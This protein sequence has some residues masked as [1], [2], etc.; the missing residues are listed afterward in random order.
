MNKKRLLEAINLITSNE[1]ETPIQVARFNELIL[2]GLDVNTQINQKKLP[3]LQIDPQGFS[4][5]HLAIIHCKRSMVNALL[6]VEHINLQSVNQDG[7]GALHMV[8]DYRDD[9]QQVTQSQK[10]IKEKQIAEAIIA[11]SRD[12]TLQDKAGNTALHKAAMNGNVYVVELFLKKDYLF[13]QQKL[14]S[15]KNKKHKNTVL[16]EVAQNGKQGKHILSLLMRVAS[17]QDLKAKNA[18]DETP[19]VMVKRLIQER[20]LLKVKFPILIALLNLLRIR[21]KHLLIGKQLKLDEKNLKLSEAELK[22]SWEQWKLH[23]EQWKLSWEQWKLSWEQWNKIN[24]DPISLK[25]FSRLTQELNSLVFH[26]KQL[27]MSSAQVLFRISDLMRRLLADEIPFKEILIKIEG[28]YLNTLSEVQRVLQLNAAYIDEL[29]EVEQ[30]LQQHDYFAWKEEKANLA[31]SF[32]DYQKSLPDPK[33]SVHVPY[34]NEGSGLAR[35]AISYYQK[36][37][38]EFYRQRY[39]TAIELLKKSLQCYDQAPHLTGH[40]NFADAYYLLGRCYQK[41]AEFSSALAVRTTHYLDAQKYLEVSRDIYLSLQDYVQ[42]E[43]VYQDLAD[44]QIKQS[45]SHYEKMQLQVLSSSDTSHQ[46][47]LCAHFALAGFYTVLNNRRY[48]NSPVSNPELEQALIAREAYHYSLAYELTQGDSVPDAHLVLQREIGVGYNV[49]LGTTNIQQCVA[50]FAFEPTS[51]KLVLAHFDKFSGPLTFIEQLLSQFPKEAQLEIYLTGGRDRSQFGRPVSDNN[52]NQ[53]MKQLYA[54]KDRISIIRTD[55]GDKSSPPAVFFDPEANRVT[56]GVAQHPEKSLHARAAK[57]CLNLDKQGDNDYL[58]PLTEINYQTQPIIKD[59]DFT[60]EEKQQ[61][62]RSYRHFYLQAYR[63]GHAYKAWYHNQLLYP[64]LSILNTYPGTEGFNKPLLTALRPIE[65][66]NRLQTLD[67]EP[68]VLLSAKERFGSNLDLVSV[69][70]DQ[71]IVGQTLLSTAD[72]G[73]RLFASLADIPSQMNKRPRFM[74]FE[75]PIEK[76]EMSYQLSQEDIADIGYSKFNAYRTTQGESRFEVENQW[77]LEKQLQAFKNSLSVDQKPARLTFILS[78]DNNYW[79]TLV[80]NYQFG[81]WQA[82]Y[83]DVKRP[84]SDPIPEIISHALRQV[85][86]IEKPYNLSDGRQVDGAYSGLWALETAGL[87]N[88]LINTNPQW[89]AVDWQTQLDKKAI[90]PEFFKAQKEYYMA[91]LQHHFVRDIRALRSAVSPPIVQACMQRK[92]R[93]FGACVSSSDRELHRERL[94]L[95]QQA[96]VWINSLSALGHLQPDWIPILS[97]AKA[98]REGKEQIT[99]YHVH[100]QTEKVIQFTDQKGFNLRNALQP[101]YK[102]LHGLLKFTLRDPELALQLLLTFKNGQSLSEQLPHFLENSESVDGLNAAFTIQTLMALFQQKSRNSLQVETGP[103]ALTLKIHTYVNLVQMGHG[104]ILDGAKVTHL[105]KALLDQEKLIQ[106]PL[107]HFRFGVKTAV[108][109]GVSLV[110][111]IISVGLDIDELSKA[112][113]EAEKSLFATQLTFD[114]AGL[115]LSVSGMG[116]AFLGAPALAVGFSGIGTIFAGLGVGVTGLV[117]AYNQVISKAQAVGQYFYQLNEA[118]RHFGY[119][120]VEDED[121]QCHMTPYGGAVITRIDFQKGEMV[122]G[123][124]FIYRSTPRSRGVFGSGYMNYISWPG[125]MPQPIRDKKQALII[126][127]RLGYPKQVP[128]GSWQKCSTWIL[129]MTPTSYLNYIYSAF[130]GAT[131]RNDPGFSVLK[132][133]EKP[134]QNGETTF[135]ASFYT[136]PSEY[137]ISQI[138]EERVE[139]HTTVLLDQLARIVVIPKLSKQDRELDRFIHYKLSADLSSEGGQCLLYLNRIGSI[140]LHSLPSNYT[141]ILNAEVLPDDTLSFTPTGITVSGI[142]IHIPQHQ[143][144]YYFIDKKKT[145]TFQ[146]DFTQAKLFITQINYENAQKHHPSLQTY[147]QSHHLLQPIHTSLPSLITLSHFPLQ[148]ESGKY[149][150]GKA[151]Y[152]AADDRLF[153]TKRLPKNFSDAAQLVHFNN[154]SAY[155]FEPTSHYFWR[156]DAQHQLAENYVF[157]S[158]FMPNKAMNNSALTGAAIVPIIAENENAIRVTQTFTNAANDTQRR[159]TYHIIDNKAPLLSSLNDDKLIMNLHIISLL[160]D[161][162]NVTTKERTRYQKALQ[163]ICANDIFNIKLA[164]DTY[165]KLPGRAVFAELN[166]I[167][168]ISSFN[169]IVSLPA[170]WVRRAK[171]TARCQLIHPQIQESAIY[172]GS[173]TTPEGNEVFY[174]FTPRSQDS[175]GQLYR[176]VAGNT[177]AR[178][179]SSTANLI[180]AFF[181]DPN[182]L[183]ALTDEGVLKKIDALGKAYTLA[184]TKEWVNNQT[185]WWEAVPNYLAENPPGRAY[186][187]LFGI[188]DAQE[189]ALAVWVDMRDHV[190]VLANTPV[191]SD[192]KP[193]QLAYLG[194]LDD[195]RFFY[196]ENKI[197]YYQTAE[198]QV[199]DT[200]FQGSKL[201]PSATLTPLNTLAVADQAYLAQQNLWLHRTGLLFSIA[202]QKGLEHWF[203]ERIET[204]WLDENRCFQQYDGS[205]KSLSGIIKNQAEYL[206]YC[207]YFTFNSQNESLVLPSSMAMQAASFQFSNDALIPLEKIAG[208]LTHWWCP[209][210]NQFFSVPP[211]K[212]ANNWVYLA[213]TS[214]QDHYFFNP[215]EKHIEIIEP[216]TTLNSNKTSH[217]LPAELALR[218]HQTLLWLMPI[219]YPQTL[220]VPLFEGIESVEMGIKLTANVTLDISVQALNHYRT[221][222][223]SQTN[224]AIVDNLNATQEGGLNLRLSVGDNDLHQWIATRDGQTIVISHVSHRCQISLVDVMNW[225]PSVAQQSSIQLNGSSDNNSTIISLLAIQNQFNT[226]LKE[227]F[228][229]AKIANANL[230]SFA[231][232]LNRF[233]RSIY[234]LHH[235]SRNQHSSFSKIV[236]EKQTDR[237]LSVM[238]GVLGGIATGGLLVSAVWMR[239]FRRGPIALPALLT[240]AIPFVLS[241]QVSEAVRM[242]QSPYK[243]GVQALSVCYQS[244]FKKHHCAKTELSFGT[245]GHCANSETSLSW[246]NAG[247]EGYAYAVSTSYI[248]SKTSDV[249]ERLFLSGNNLYFLHSSQCQQKLNVET[250]QDITFSAMISRSSVFYQLM[251]TAAH[252]QELIKRWQIEQAQEQFA[253]GVKAISF[254]YLG[255]QCVLHTRIGNIFQAIGLQPNW[256]QQDPSYWVRRITLSLLSPQCLSKA[257]LSAVCLETGLLHPRIQVALRHTD[258]YLSKLLIRFM[259]DLLQWGFSSSITIASI[260]DI[261]SY[262][263]SWRY[264]MA[265]GLCAALAMLEV[266]NDPSMGYLVMALFILPQI[267]YWLENV[268]IPITHYISSTIKM[269]EKLL[270]S[271]SLWLSI[272]DDPQRL[273][274]QEIVL[275]AANQRVL[276]GK[277]RVALV[278]KTMIG[279]FKKPSASNTAQSEEVNFTQLSRYQ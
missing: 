270:L 12:V 217:R 263:H 228:G 121:N 257:S 31:S 250:I 28:I 26:S 2:N 191:K 18:F 245:L 154:D 160:T 85:L 209:T 93:S 129:P 203:L 47:K 202:P 67:T 150:L 142:P 66:E 232:P 40:I 149:Y 225:I 213:K 51:K 184:F 226:T 3:E 98:L 275:Q 221:L 241:P 204:Q 62:T 122:Y 255:E 22:L 92:K 118:Y 210:Q 7:E 73:K 197:I 74:S 234:A 109:E 222:V 83:V 165:P 195:K 176:L 43:K 113:T 32:F 173:L 183:L 102:K 208:Q 244:F 141:W 70:S 101:I 170:I 49:K 69:I 137:G 243:E 144:N 220:S 14:L 148:N 33:L 152:A 52:I 242:V 29:L 256:Q 65:E 114:S 75:E 111:N 190:F 253:Q 258:T 187:P 218:S 264:E 251:D 182:T 266:V 24:A 112:K 100:Q 179:L 4:L 229:S 107:S 201:N 110:L 90:N 15:I 262:P 199:H 156:T 120:K 143:S 259:A 161:S 168:R 198:T 41:Q 155:F 30:T 246:F 94:N 163:R 96:D 211:Q 82:F 269:F 164:H 186:I 88:Q 106:K 60:L 193:L 278:K 45:N 180:S 215:N 71:S 86:A 125:D 223:F 99:F 175:S 231:R 53:V 205:K 127:E 239:Y 21:S 44:I 236:T 13:P 132:E 194:E 279:F 162:F 95:L 151:Y 261:L 19:L 196:S 61:L 104:I 274:S 153:Y 58:Y 5:L 131:T 265:M 77:Y 134:N 249:Q 42:L 91:L 130:L 235:D 46:E 207:F 147:L 57:M 224:L 54:Y 16:H 56:Q 206:K 23:G 185:K 277:E 140:Q 126:R 272:Q 276:Q 177:R 108:T 36:G 81:S 117:Q 238:L 214:N 79:V 78:L 216:D 252:K 48:A 157:L 55:L 166:S 84:S 10:M 273:K 260:V 219:A 139:T 240:A 37:V 159:V 247:N 76:S 105:V 64:L 188:A 248:S 97:S 268:G 34:I 115:L 50:V 171:T 181:N 237:S 1:E 212:N 25:I 192:G 103:L 128:L 80:L 123:S 8:A 146:L 145:I 27:S 89:Q 124:Q 172:L 20:S 17:E 136:F 72:K 233:V 133:L 227:N 254:S 174:F 9:E 116:A 39:I 158:E 200:L 68:S 169:Q 119:E 11:R 135:D 63:Q 178:H 189:N 35:E 271:C 38:D 87:I 138:T 230:S 267:P 59:Q 167:I 6:A